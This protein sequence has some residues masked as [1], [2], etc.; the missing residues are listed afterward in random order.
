MQIPS[1]QTCAMCTFTITTHWRK[2][3]VKHVDAYSRRR[4]NEFN[5]CVRKATATESYSFSF[6]FYLPSYFF[7]NF[8]LLILSAL[9]LAL[10]RSFFPSSTERNSR[11]SIFAGCVCVCCAFC[12]AC[13][14]VVRADEYAVKWYTLDPLSRRVDCDLA[15]CRHTQTAS[16]K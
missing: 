15:A 8:F 13:V 6:S 5:E 10:V 16:S 1:K 9:A 12:E 7:C 2:T 11:G 14:V 3:I 4:K